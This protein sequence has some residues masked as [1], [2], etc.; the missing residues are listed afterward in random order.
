MGIELGKEY[1]NTPGEKSVRRWSLQETA[2]Q[3][4]DH[5]T[6]WKTIWQH[7]IEVPKMFSPF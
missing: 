4:L 2:G 6:F 3:D 1:G 5:V 7:L